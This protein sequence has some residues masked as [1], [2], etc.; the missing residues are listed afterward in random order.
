MDETA[1]VSERLSRLEDLLEI[2]GLFVDYGRM[3]DEA[4]HAGYAALFTEDGE[5]DLG[6][7]GGARGRGRDPCVDGAHLGTPGQ[8]VSHHQQPAGGARR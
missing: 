1:A 5:V 7:H 6:P 4:D 3:C 8:L 2:Q